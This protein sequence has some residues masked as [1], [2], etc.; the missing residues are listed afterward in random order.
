M[1]CAAAGGDSPPAAVVPW[2]S[3]A[4]LSMDAPL[5]LFTFVLDVELVAVL[6][7][8]RLLML[9]SIV[10]DPALAPALQSHGAAMARDRAAEGKESH[11]T[12][13][14]CLRRRP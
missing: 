1:S 8:A 7:D 13:P 12:C 9:T 2:N 6:L 11:R 10:D 3:V 4:E 14:T 5:L